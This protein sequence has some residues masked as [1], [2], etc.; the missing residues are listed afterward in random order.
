M[1]DTLE[2]LLSRL[3]NATAKREAENI[4]AGRPKNWR[5]RIDR[6]ECSWREDAR[7]TDDWTIGGTEFQ[8]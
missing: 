7:F 2:D 8:L 5:T 6:N 3:R 1:T 4:A